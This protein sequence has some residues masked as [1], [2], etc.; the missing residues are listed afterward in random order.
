[1]RKQ[2]HCRAN[3]VNLS[4]FQCKLAFTDGT[5]NTS[6]VALRLCENVT[7]VESVNRTSPISGIDVGARED[8]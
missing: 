4:S 5:C 7:S 1:M 2:S 8:C 6:D 3:P